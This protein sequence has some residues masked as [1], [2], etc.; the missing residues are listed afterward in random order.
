MFPAARLTDLTVTG[1]LVTGPGVPNVLI[2]NLPAAVLG[3]MVSGAACVGTLVSGCSMTVLISG[4][5]A[6]R[7]TAMA[8]GA[9]PVTGI[10]VTTMIAPP[11]CPTVL[12]GG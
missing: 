12:I 11:A 3:D 7:V 8:S 6:A 1:D 2:G 10:P 9:N 4:R 5:P